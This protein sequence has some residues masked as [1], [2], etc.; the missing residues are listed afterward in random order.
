MNEQLV[1]FLEGD[2]R[3]D[4]HR[5]FAD[6]IP[7]FSPEALESVHN[8]VQWVFPLYES[9]IYNPTAPLLDDETVAYL[10]ES[11]KFNLRIT[12]ATLRLAAYY[13]VG[14]D[15]Y[16]HSYVARGVKPPWVTMNNHNYQ[17]ITRI[18]KNLTILGKHSIAQ[19][20]FDH[21]HDIYIKYPKLVGDRTMDFWESAI[22]TS[23]PMDQPW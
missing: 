9:S 6:I 14:L 17:R 20:F 7:G 15:G 12:Y 22:T 1:K 8:W 13:F 21:A 5:L 18:L 2:G 11:K 16:D 23:D 3:D 10:R 4:H 19:D